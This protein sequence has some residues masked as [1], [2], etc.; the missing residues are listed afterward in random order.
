MRRIIGTTFSIPNLSEKPVVAGNQQLGAA[1]GFSVPA[2]IREAGHDTIRRFVEFFTANI[3]NENTRMAY[4]RAVRRF[5]S[6]AE[7]RGISLAAAEPIL[8]ASYIEELRKAYSDLTVKQHLAAIRMLFDYLVTGGVL[9]VNPASS[10]RGPKVVII[11]G[12]TPV[13]SAKDARE[14]LDSIDT[15][16]LVGLRDR[17]LI[18]VMVFTFARVG[19]ALHVNVRDVFRNSRRYWVRL[20]EKGGRYHEMPLSHNA[21]VYLTEYMDAAGLHEQPDTP[22]FRT[23]GRRQYI[24]PTRMH[25]NDALRMIK[26]RARQVGLS[27]NICCHTFRATGITEYM[28]NGGTLEKAQQMAAHASS[29]TT[30]LYN[31]VR[32]EVTL[33]EVERVLI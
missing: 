9:R 6:W 26:H 10:V 30:N 27:P 1:S 20:H 32:D 16:T 25:R 4:L 23:I 3:R 14:L 18:G 7:R 13:L 11:K 31:R 21:E 5:C 24:T 33:D 28:R 17:A 29:R 19:A 2:V 12:K 8:V 15:T 22:L